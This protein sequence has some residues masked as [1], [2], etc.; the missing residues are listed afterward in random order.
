MFCN[1]S[2]GK[3]QLLRILLVIALA[4]FASWIYLG[5]KPNQSV[6]P[7]KEDPWQLTGNDAERYQHYLV[8]AVFSPWADDLIKRADLKKDDRVLDVACGTGVVTRLASQMLGES[9]SITGLDLSPDML[10]V[11]RALPPPPGPVIDWREGNALSLPFPSGS[12]H[13]VLCQ[14]GLQFFPNQA[15]ALREMH[16]VLTPNGRV[17]VSV[18]YSLNKNP[19]PAALAKA[20]RKYLD[21]DS[22]VEMGFPFAFDDPE[23]L[24]SLLVSAGFRQVTIDDV[25]IEMR[26]NTLPEFFIG[27][28]SVFPFY[29]AL[30]AKDPVE[31]E[32]FI[33][34][35]FE[36]LRPYIRNGEFR[37]AWR[38]IVG[39]ATK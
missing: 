3:S 10:E 27:H 30:T 19:Y 39:I 6:A 1:R 2:I 37:V 28:L 29:P 23:E 4:G 16:R 33:D 25:E 11:A 18:W 20:I 24:R 32:L 8:P 13:K 21:N 26:V 15:K 12:F 7:I 35:V 17:A 36:L 9:G 31:R 14:Q 22:A 34:E 5:C 38:A